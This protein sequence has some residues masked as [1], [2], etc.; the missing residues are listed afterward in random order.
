[1]S[2]NICRLVYDSPVGH[3]ESYKTLIELQSVVLGVPQLRVGAH[4]G[5]NRVVILLLDVGQVRV[6]CL[7]DA[8]S[9]QQL[10]P[11][12]LGPKT[13]QT[14]IFNGIFFIL[15]FNAT[16]RK[17]DFPPRDFSQISSVISD[18]H[19][20]LRFPY[21]LIIFFVDFFCTLRFVSETCLRNLSQDFSKVFPPTDYLRFI[22]KK[23]FIEKK[24]ASSQVPPTSQIW[25]QFIH[26]F[27]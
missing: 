19:I 12:L 22:E 5:Q 23:E 15:S 10:L 6:H 24:L 3:D 26:R 9:L 27:I 4:E 7:R 16:R 18:Y 20:Y 8:C 13:V 21:R 1:M 25:L 14:H 2:C 11:L 17:Q